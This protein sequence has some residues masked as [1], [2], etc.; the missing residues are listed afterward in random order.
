MLHPREV[1]ESALLLLLLPP[2]L[3]LGNSLLLRPKPLAIPRPPRDRERCA[4]KAPTQHLR[5]RTL[6][7]D[8][9]PRTRLGFCRCWPL[10]DGWLALH[11]LGGFV[12]LGVGSPSVPGSPFVLFMI[13]RICADASVTLRRGCFFPPPWAAATA[14]DTGASSST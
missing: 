1:Q 2:S 13:S 4:I 11:L 7:I 10:Q 12:F 9:S 5:T 14:C 8:A 3:R 6:H